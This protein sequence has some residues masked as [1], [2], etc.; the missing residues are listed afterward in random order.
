MT[1]IANSESIQS[2]DDNQDETNVLRQTYC[3][4]QFQ[5]RFRTDRIVT[6][7]RTLYEKSDQQYSSVGVIK[8]NL[9]D[10]S[11][12]GPYHMVSIL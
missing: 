12:Y 3:T 7:I 6:Q 11:G 4:N 9:L 5:R 10:Q 2:L 1:L 8:S